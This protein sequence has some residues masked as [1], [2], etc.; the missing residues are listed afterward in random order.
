MI[1]LKNCVIN[2]IL[3]SFICRLTGEYLYIEG[4][5]GMRN[6]MQKFEELI[7]CDIYELAFKSEISEAVNGVVSKASPIAY[8]CD[9]VDFLFAVLD[10]IDL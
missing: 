7:Y 3:H 10:K 2:V 1:V 8:I 6:C 5:K 9:L 4:E